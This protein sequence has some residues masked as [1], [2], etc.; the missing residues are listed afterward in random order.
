MCADR[1]CYSCMVPHAK[2]KAAHEE[3]EQEQI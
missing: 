2:F 1:L 3:Q